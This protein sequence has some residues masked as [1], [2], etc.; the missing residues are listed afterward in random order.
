MAYIRRFLILR[1]G[2]TIRSQNQEEN[3]VCRENG[4]AGKP[5]LHDPGNF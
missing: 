1:T 2:K 3:D 5:P 4:G